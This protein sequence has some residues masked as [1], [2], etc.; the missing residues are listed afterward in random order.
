MRREDH[1]CI[2]LQGGLLDTFSS[3]TGLDRVDVDLIFRLAEDF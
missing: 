2:I 3:P 1:A